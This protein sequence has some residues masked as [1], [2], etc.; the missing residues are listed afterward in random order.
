ME[1]YPS[2]LTIFESD[3]RKVTT[4]FL[5]K[6]IRNAMPFALLVT[7][8]LIGVSLFGGGMPRIEQTTLMYLIL[9]LVTMAAVVKSCIPF[10]KAEGIYLCNHGD[11]HLRRFVFPA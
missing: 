4:G 8:L 5:K 7:V 11:R 10:Y 9:I 2:F 6:A 3:T 1:A